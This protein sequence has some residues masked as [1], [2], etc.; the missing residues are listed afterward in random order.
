MSDIRD[1]VLYTKSDEWV[2]V[3][4]GIATIGITDYAQSHLGD[5]VFVEPCEKGKE[6]KKEDVL[7][8]IE[9]VKSASDIYSP[10]TGTIT[11]YNDEIEE[12]SGIINK[13]PYEG[14]WICK[15]KLADDEELKGLLSSKEYLAEKEED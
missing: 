1:D 8:T 6:I 9:S 12:E 7:T 4:D 13:E 2:K 11:E 15:I 3:E 5:V 10:V 14:G